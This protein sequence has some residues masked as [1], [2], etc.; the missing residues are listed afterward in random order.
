MTTLDT[1][2]QAPSAPLISRKTAV[3]LGQLG[4]AALLLLAWQWASDAFGI[5]FFAPPL[6]VLHRLYE[7]A[8]NG[9]MFWHIVATLRVSAIGFVIALVAGLILPFLLR[10]SPR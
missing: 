6:A 8:I 2:V 1:I 5:I 3:V 7:T 10:L 4:F 9:E